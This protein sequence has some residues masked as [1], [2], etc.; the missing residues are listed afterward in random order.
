MS[1][2][3]CRAGFNFLVAACVGG[4][5]SS[6]PGV[7]WPLADVRQAGVA[8]SHGCGRVF[9]RFGGARLLARFRPTVSVLCFG[10]VVFFGAP[11]CVMPCLAVLRRADLCCVAVRSAL[12]CRAAPCRAVV[13]HAVSSLAAPC[14]AAPRHVVLW[15]VVSWGA[16]S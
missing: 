5:L 1:L 13:C 15:C 11:C 12:L 3:L 2:R 4:P 6:L 14:C 16:L 7:P 9:F 8:L 10:A